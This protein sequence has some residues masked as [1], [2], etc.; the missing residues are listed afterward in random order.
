M[1][2]ITQKASV[3]DLLSRLGSPWQLM[4]IPTF[5]F[6]DESGFMPS[7]AFKTS[8]FSSLEFALTAILLALT[9]PLSSEELFD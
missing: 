6:K 3:F 9:I 2:Q 1:S 5:C 8:S 7:A 4:V